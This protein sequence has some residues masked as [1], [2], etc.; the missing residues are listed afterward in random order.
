MLALAGSVWAIW[1]GPGCAGC[2]QAKAAFGWNI[3]WLGVVYYTLL[4]AWFWQSGLSRWVIGGLMAAVGTHLEL[5]YLLWREEIFCPACLV[6][7]VGAFVAGISVWRSVAN[8]F[9]NLIWP[10]PVLALLTL[11]AFNLQQ[12]AASAEHQR[13]TDA[14]VAT[15]LVEKISVAEGQARLLVYSR[16]D[17][18]FCQLFDEET[19]PQLQR[20]LG[21]NLV[22]E[23]R[24]ATG[25]L[26]TPAF[27]V[28]GRENLGCLGLPEYAHL[29]NLLHRA[30][31]PFL[32]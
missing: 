29:T 20:D 25:T 2:Q 11:T 5:V 6:T 21:T 19:L 1:A 4:T 31:A 15:V 14:L 23:R 17:C 7:A 26:P 28:L 8:N 10:L 18:K 9:N 16:P 12:R 24:S 22:V 13:Q 3:A 27:V 32:R 30:R